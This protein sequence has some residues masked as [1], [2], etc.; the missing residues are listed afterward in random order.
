VAVG[1]GVFVAVGVATA[2][3]SV[4]ELLAVFESTPLLPSSVT[5][6]VF[7]MLPL[8]ATTSTANCRL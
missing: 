7:V 5:E 3:M 1:V 8:D 4:A 6:A 2:S